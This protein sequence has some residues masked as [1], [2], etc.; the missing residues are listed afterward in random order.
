MMTIER[1]ARKARR[2]KF[3]SALSACSAFFLITGLAF[4]GTAAPTPAMATATFAGGCFWSME[5]VFDDLPGVV[6]VTV[7]YAGG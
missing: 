2:D 5:H 7:G 3:F 4:V 1:G 6:S